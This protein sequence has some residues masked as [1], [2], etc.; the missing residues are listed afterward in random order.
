VSRPSFTSVVGV[1]ALAALAL[2]SGLAAWREARP[3]ELCPEGM[4]LLGSR[5]CGEGQT[6]ESGR[7]RGTPRRCSEEQEVSPEGCRPRPGKVPLQGGRVER[8]PTD[9]DD[10]GGASAPIEVEAFEL[11]RHEVTEIEYAACVAAGVSAPTKTRGEPGLPQTDVTAKDAA[12]CCA[13]RGG[14]LPTRAQLAY[15]A[16]GAVGRRYP[17]GDAGAVCRRVSHGL[18]VGPCARGADG[19]QLAGSHP[20]GRTPEGVLDLAGN[21]E[22]WALSGGG[23]EARGGSFRDESV[24]ALRNFSRRPVARDGGEDF[25]GFRCVYAAASR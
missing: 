14:A 7:C 11:D 13:H 10:R 22:E 16:M 17:W 2:G 8:R 9:W 21:V 18:V 23:L 4:V 20:S 6:L 25:R 5:C 24:T 1:G 12:A 19:P 3:P 15:A